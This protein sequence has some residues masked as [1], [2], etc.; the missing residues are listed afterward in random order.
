MSESV[1]VQVYFVTF[2]LTCD[3]WAL[4]KICEYAAA[5]PP[6]GGPNLGVKT[7][8]LIDCIE[9]DRY[10]VPILH[11][12]LGLVNDVLKNLLA[13]IDKRRG[14]ETFPPIVLEAREE[15][16][17]ACLDLKDCKEAS[18]IWDHMYGPILAEKRLY[19][20]QLI[21]WL[22]LPRGILFGE[23]R[24]CMVVDKDDYTSEIGNL[25]RE[26]QKVESEANAARKAEV[27]AAKEMEKGGFFG[28][29]S[30]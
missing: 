2:I 16:I 8:P 12:Q 29:D 10:V 3:Q 26:K 1:P 19:R 20:S 30:R 28:E 25:L 7:K 24:A 9:L 14:L 5:R 15:Y 18:V 21:E 22:K 17:Q 11:L 4:A 6:G 27:A 23:E 13:Y